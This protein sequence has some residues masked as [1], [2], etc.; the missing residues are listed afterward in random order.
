MRF[1]EQ[2]NIDRVYADFLGKL[3]TVSGCLRLGVVPRSDRLY[4]RNEG[5]AV[6]SELVAGGAIVTFDA[7]EVA[8]VFHRPECFTEHLRADRDEMATEFT[9]P[10][11]TLSEALRDHCRPAS[12]D[13]DRVGTHRA[14]RIEGGQLI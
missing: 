1:V 11:W 10:A 4:E 14:A 8:V 13:L 2:S 12:A 5:F 7:G 6:G 9:E 3:G